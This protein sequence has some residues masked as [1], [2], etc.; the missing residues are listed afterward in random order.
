MKILEWKTIFPIEELRIK[1]NITNIMVGN[2]ITNYSH[3]VK[4][5]FLPES[6]MLNIDGYHFLALLH[7]YLEELEIEECIENGLQ[8]ISSSLINLISL[9]ISYSYSVSSAEWD[10]LS[11][12][13][14]L[15]KIDLCR[16][17]ELNDA[18]VVNYST[19]TKVKSIKVSHCHG[20]S[21]LGLSYLVANKELLVELEIVYCDGIS[22]EGCHCL[23]TLI[24]LTSLTVIYGKLND[25]GELIF[26]LIFSLLFS[27]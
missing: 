22:S 8:V 20:L 1:E 6:S 16:M 14:N 13:T 4:K 18:S 11:K 12:L 27:I 2:M 7:P 10:S 9:T 23:T 19:L 5:L 24:N 25:I 26:C 21:G 3:K 17:K 15:E